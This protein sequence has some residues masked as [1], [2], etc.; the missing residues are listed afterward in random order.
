MSDFLFWIKKRR[1]ELKRELLELDA[2]EKMF[3][4]SGIEP[5]K[6]PMLPFTE[7]ETR[8]LELADHKKQTIKEAVIAVLGTGPKHGL[9]ANEILDRLKRVYDDSLVRTSLSPQ[10]SRLKQEKKIVSNRPYWRL[11]D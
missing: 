10:L 2:A 4:K 3:L 9:T 7:A 1:E 6:S 5:V 8:A 11:P